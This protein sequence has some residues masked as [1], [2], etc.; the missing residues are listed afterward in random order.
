MSAY[1]CRQVHRGLLL[2][3]HS[4]PV[5]A[6]TWVCGFLAF[7]YLLLSTA[8]GDLCQ[9]RRGHW[10]RLSTLAS[11][12]GNRRQARNKKK[13]RARPTQTLMQSHHVMRWQLPATATTT[14][15]GHWR[16]CERRR[17]SINGARPTTLGDE[18][19]SCNDATSTVITTAPPEAA[20]TSTTAVASTMSTPA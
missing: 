4:L 20:T 17:A 13:R 2:I 8:T 15:H 11:P 19:R 1:C 7:S 12:T 9:R 16:H 3:C 10:S 14:A 18:R 5:C 6:K